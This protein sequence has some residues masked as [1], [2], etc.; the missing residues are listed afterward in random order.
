M[1]HASFRGVA[2]LHGHALKFHKRSVDGSA[3]CNF[4]AAPG[5]VVIGAIFEVPSDEKQELDRAEGLGD[6][7]E[8]QEVKVVAE[9]GE[10][11]RVVA[12]VATSA[13]MDGRLQPYTWYREYVIRGARAHGFPSVYIEAIAAVAAIPDPDQRREARELAVLGSDG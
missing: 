11:R 13:H 12:Y 2:R 6:G 1:P 5:G 9:D 10:E 7:Y 3:K 4:V 8:E